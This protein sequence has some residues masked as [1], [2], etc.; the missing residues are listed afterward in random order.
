M[1]WLLTRAWS[2]PLRTQSQLTDPGQRIEACKCSKEEKEKKKVNM[3]ILA[4][5][6]SRQ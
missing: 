6:I 5:S 3:R 2:Y 4:C 1:G